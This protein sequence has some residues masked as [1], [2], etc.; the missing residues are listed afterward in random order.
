MV[1]PVGHDA[2]GSLQK[3]VLPVGLDIVTPPPSGRIGGVPPVM[4]SVEISLALSPFRRAAPCRD[5]RDALRV[6]EA[7]RLSIESAAEDDDD[8]LAVGNFD[9]V[10]STGL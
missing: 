10:A 6:V 8:E 5:P 9:P 7:H 2:S 1:L 3:R 4:Q